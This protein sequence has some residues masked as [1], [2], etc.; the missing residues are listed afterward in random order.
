MRNYYSLHTS[1]IPIYRLV[2]LF[3]WHIQ[4]IQIRDV[5]LSL[6]WTN[7]DIMSEQFDQ[8]KTQ[9]LP[10]LNREKKH[11]QHKLLKIRTRN[12]KHEQFHN[13]FH[14][15]HHMGLNFLITILFLIKHEWINLEL[16][17]Y[18]VKNLTNKSLALGVTMKS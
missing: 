6:S 9:N 7:M 14:E 11:A 5:E 2:Y 10:I 1:I 4:S 8:F 18:F 12:M 15:S 17:R 3:K 13:W 16:S